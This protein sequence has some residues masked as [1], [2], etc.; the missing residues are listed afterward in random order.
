MAEKTDLENP[1]FKTG[2][3]FAVLFIVCVSAF[4]LFWAVFGIWSYMYPSDVSYNFQLPKKSS[5]EISLFGKGNTF[6]VSLPAQQIQLAEAVLPYHTLDIQIA[7]AI[8]RPSDKS[9]ILSRLPVIQ[10]ALIS[11]FRTLTLEQ[12]QENGRLFYL[13]E[14]LLGQVN[15]LLYP[16]QIRD[17]LF[18]K[19]VVREGS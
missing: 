13:K 16:V 3:V 11:N 4:A 17:V 18:Q 10:D 8:E 5:E 19:I 1:S 14:S 6:F 9:E 7:F 2:K 12:L 15:N